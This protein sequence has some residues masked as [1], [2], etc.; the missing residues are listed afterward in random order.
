M[1]IDLLDAKRLVVEWLHYVC[2]GLPEHHRGSEGDRWCGECPSCHM[3]KAIDSNQIVLMAK[4]EAEALR[5]VAEVAGGFMKL[6]TRTMEARATFVDLQTALAAL[7][8]LKVQ[9]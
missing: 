7:D 8:A 1:A 9:S 5:E 6:D 3:S 2:N 4:A